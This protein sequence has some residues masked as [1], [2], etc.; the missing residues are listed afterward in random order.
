ML[1]VR[2]ALAKH[3]PEYLSEA[4]ALGTFMVGAGLVTVLLESLR[5][6]VR[7]VLTD[8]GTRRAIIGLAMGVTAIVL[9]YSPWGQS[10]GAHMNPAVT[11][12]YLLL[13][14]IRAGDAIFYCAAQVAGAIAGV[15]LVW[16]I[17]GD[18]F[19]VP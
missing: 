14:K 12:S 16:W 15:L 6:P 7:E 3:W 1:T 13:G 4:W 5:S 11:L 2:E 10:S 19:S 18:A 9:I 8:A 17:V